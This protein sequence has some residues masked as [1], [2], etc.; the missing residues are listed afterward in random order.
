MPPAIFAP[1]LLHGQV[2]LITGGGS[3]IGAECA[4]VLGAAGARIA[5]AS[6]K[7][8]RIAKAARG[9]SEE[10]GQP[11]LGVPCDIR[12][13][14]SVTA[15]V[16]AVVEEFGRIDILVNNG[17]GQ[18]LSPA[19]AIRPKGWD[20]VIGT[21]LTGTWNVTRAV[22]DAWMLQNGG[23]I[24]NI[25]MMTN[26]GFAGMAHSAAARS[27]VESLGRS[28]AVE[29]AQRGIT[30]NA[31]QPGIIATGGIRQYPMWEAVMDQAQRSIPAK[32]LGRPEEVAWL[33]AFLA[34]PAGAYITGQTIGIDGGRQLWGD[35]WPV[36]DPDPMPAIDVPVLPWESDS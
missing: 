35:S 34:G 12:D 2:A 21:N 5:I 4:R 7:P 15:L 30:V 1:D 32:R 27:G 23:R 16:Q 13:R 19:E 24:I 6:R 22:A 33:V 31:I 20:A 10:L 26:R 11:V 28:L 18:F 36:P 29:W 3:G 25:T 14:D 8:D 9:L 17:G